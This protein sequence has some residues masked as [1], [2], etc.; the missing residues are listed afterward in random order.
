M[1]RRRISQ[2]ENNA[3]IWSNSLSLVLLPDINIPIIYCYYILYNYLL[4]LVL[5][6]T[7]F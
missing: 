1:L 6:F 2:K 4:S 3:P 5:L 7:A